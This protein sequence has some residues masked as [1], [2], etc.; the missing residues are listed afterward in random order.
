MIRSWHARAVGE[1]SAALIRL[2][3]REPRSGALVSSGSAS[4]SRLPSGMTA[5]AIVR[6]PPAD[7]RSPKAARVTSPALL[8]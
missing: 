5:L 1:S 4:A 3:R 7:P 2:T 8:T 6:W